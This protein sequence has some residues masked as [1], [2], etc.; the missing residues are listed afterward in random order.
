[1]GMD[2]VTFEDGLTYADRVLYG[3]LFF[4]VVGVI[5]FDIVTGIIIDK[6]SAMREADLERDAWRVGTSFIA[7]IDRSWYEEQGCKF[8]VL[9]NEHQKWKTTCFSFRTFERRRPATTPEQ[10]Q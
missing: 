8:E 7:F 10:R 9:E 1:M 2:V 4:L 3:L 6:F 5:L